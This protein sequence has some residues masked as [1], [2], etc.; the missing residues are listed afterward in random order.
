M[1]EKF[2]SDYFFK[3]N[4]MLFEGACILFKARENKKN[5]LGKKF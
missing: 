3:E 2:W 1:N 4:K 5:A